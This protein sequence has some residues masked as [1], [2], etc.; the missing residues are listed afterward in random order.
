MK[1]KKNKE[2]LSNSRQSRTRKEHSSRKFGM[3]VTGFALAMAFFLFNNT[4]ADA[5][6]A[7]LK[8][9]S[10]VLGINANGNIEVSNVGKGKVTYTSSNKKI[11]TI[12]K[13]GV[14]KGIKAG[15]VKIKVEY[16]NNKKT[17]T[18]GQVK[19]AVKNAQLGMYEEGDAIYSSQP[20]YYKEYLHYVV[21][22]DYD[23]AYRNPDAS[24]ECSSSDKNVLS[25]AKDGRI[26]DANGDGQVTVT[27]KE[28]YKKK[29]RNIGKF[30]VTVISPK[31]EGDSEFTIVKGEILDISTQ[32]R[33]AD[34]CGC[35][36]TD[37]K[38]QQ[39]D[40]NQNPELLKKT[41]GV[42]Q[43]HRDSG[44]GW[45]YGEIK[46]NH[47]GTGYVYLYMYDYNQEKYTDVI[48]EI[49]VH[50]IEVPEI[51][52]I[53][54]GLD[55]YLDN[56]DYNAEN[57]YILQTNSSEYMNIYQTP[58]NY[59]GD[60]TVTSSD[61]SVASAFMKKNEYYYTDGNAGTFYIN[62]YHSGTAVIKVAANGAE[63][64]YK[65]TVKPGNYY[66][67]NEYEVNTILQEI[68]ENFDKDLLTFQSSDSS[69]AEIC[70]NYSN[71]YNDVLFLTFDFRTKDKTGEATLNI[72]YDGSEIYSTTVTIVDYDE[73]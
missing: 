26:L 14:V 29:T 59:T 65:I 58:Y 13:K 57:G 35:L 28:K 9:K 71:P 36:C 27:V 4:T 32:L 70:Y 12:S 18:L 66:M 10:I 50:V 17:K 39:V 47:E 53:E 11:A 19:V 51:T 2:A 30:S 23:I 64:E 55:Q 48:A 24:Y 41:D 49:T 72:L 61:P 38:G 15:T 3:I 33:Y 60:Y 63:K 67:D 25:L 16:T 45:Y 40:I 34:S 68:P 73:E 5:A 69:I 52:E 31:Y 37:T 1:N 43:T 62:T 54:T 20:G 44:G 46:A 21:S 6:T 22:L 42:L 8:S 7:K 56:Y